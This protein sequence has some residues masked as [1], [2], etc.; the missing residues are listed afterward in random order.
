MAA[1]ELAAHRL[2][3]LFYSKD[4]LGTNEPPMKYGPVP[5]SQKLRNQNDGRHEHDK[6]ETVGPKKALVSNRVASCKTKLDLKFIIN[7]HFKR[8]SIILVIFTI[9]I[10]LII[11]MVLI[12]GVWQG[13]TMDSLKFHPCP[14]CP[15][16]LCPAGRPPLKRCYGHFRDGPPASIIPLDTRCCMP[17]VAVPVAGHADLRKPGLLETSAARQNA[18]QHAQGCKHV[19]TRTGYFILLI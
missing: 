4:P 12:M 1:Q 14:P 5:D 6:K 19:Q 7:N 17:M 18:V 15:N 3:V 13:L 9:P 8:S 2:N 16:L 11:L 10:I